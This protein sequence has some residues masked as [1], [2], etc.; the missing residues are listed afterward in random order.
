MDAYP[1]C[2]KIVMVDRVL[3]IN[4]VMKCDIC[5]VVLSR[6]HSNGVI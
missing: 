2:C 3:L 4:F 1:S 6:S 5:I